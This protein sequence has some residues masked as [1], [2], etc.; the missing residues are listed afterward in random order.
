M[1]PL[2]TYPGNMEDSSSDTPRTRAQGAEGLQA[3]SEEAKCIIS[4]VVVRKVVARSSVWVSQASVIGN[5]EHGE[6]NL[7]CPDKRAR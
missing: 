6:K 5:R 3:W 1:D 2:P 4:Y 7:H